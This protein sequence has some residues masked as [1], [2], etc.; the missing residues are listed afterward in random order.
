M[1]RRKHL[2]LKN[3]LEL[4]VEALQDAAALVAEGATI[5]T[6]T[7]ENIRDFADMFSEAAATMPGPSIHDKVIG[8]K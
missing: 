1:P 4:N 6:W 7:P 2:P 3:E 5:V 8:G